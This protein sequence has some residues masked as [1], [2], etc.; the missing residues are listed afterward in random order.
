MLVPAKGKITPAR[1]CKNQDVVSASWN[2]R[3][4]FILSG[5]TTSFGRGQSELAL[6]EGNRCIGGI[7][8]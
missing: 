4:L 6:P 8:Q 2:T 5:K 7:M 3:K 1:E